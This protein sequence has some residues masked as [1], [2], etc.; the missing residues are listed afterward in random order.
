MGFFLTFINIF[1]CFFGKILCLLTHLS[2]E[3][4]AVFKLMGMSF[5]NS[6]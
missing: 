5:K 4:V 3:V 2:N 6:F 1:Y